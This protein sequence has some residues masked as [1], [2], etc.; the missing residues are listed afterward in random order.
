MPNCVQ[1]MSL[2]YR[3]IGGLGHLG[4]QFARHMGFYT[5]AIARGKEKEQLALELGAQKY[6]DSDA[7]DVGKAL[8]KLG[9][10]NAILATAASGKSMAPLLGGL[11]A[12]GKLIV[13]GVSNEP[14]E[15]L[16]PELIMGTKTIEGSASGAAM[17]IED[18]L[19]F[20]CQ[21]H[22][23]S[24]NEVVSLEQAP[25]AYAK[26]LKNAARFRMVLKISARG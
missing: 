25:A 23:H 13:V 2:P 16:T 18:T 5:V 12:R 20:S 10:V 22:V 1:E 17:D 19:R 14:I 24:M 7:E 4:V 9:G 21:A 8:Q 3:G 15:I 11:K 6:I 26:M